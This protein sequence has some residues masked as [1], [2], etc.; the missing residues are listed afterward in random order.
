MASRARRS[1][2]GSSASRD[3]SPSPAPTHQVHYWN[4]VGTDGKE[5]THALAQLEPKSGVVKIFNTNSRR[6]VAPAGAIGRDLL[7]DVGNGMNLHNVPVEDYI[8]SLRALGVNDVH[9]LGAKRTR[10]APGAGSS[11]SA[12]KHNDDI[13]VNVTVAGKSF[14]LGSKEYEN[15]LHYNPKA[16]IDTLVGPG[17]SRAQLVGRALQ[18]ELSAG[19]LN[20][21]DKREVYIEKRRADGRTSRIP[22][23]VGQYAWV[24]NLLRTGSTPTEGY[25]SKE[26]RKEVAAENKARRS[27][28]GAS[29]RPPFDISIPAGASRRGGKGVSLIKYGGPSHIKALLEGKTPETFDRLLDAHSQDYTDDQVQRLKAWVSEKVRSLR[30]GARTAPTR[31][32]S[33]SPARPAARSRSPSPTRAPS[34]VASDFQ[35]EEEEEEEFTAPRRSPPRAAPASRVQATPTRVRRTVV[36]Q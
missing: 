25:M 12:L 13:V 8:S 29:D 14:A 3:R 2:V 19:N 24:Q 4:V 10:A 6:Y 20:P 15:F 23:I 11:A 1:S 18:R 30:G 33:P 28:S 35:E 36:P 27:S 34:P 21:N 17:D 9:A 16:L 31:S 22:V 5:K 7:R 26:R 32:R